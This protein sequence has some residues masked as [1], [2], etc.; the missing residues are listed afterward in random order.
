MNIFALGLIQ[1]YK[2]VHGT[3]GGIHVDRDSALHAL[4]ERYGVPVWA[5]IGQLEVTLSDYAEVTHADLSDPR[6]LGSILNSALPEAAVAAG[7]HEHGLEV[8]Y[9]PNGRSNKIAGTF[10]S[11]DTEYG[12]SFELHL[13][14]PQGGTSKSTHQFAGDDIETTP[15]FAGFAEAAPPDILLFLACHLSGTGVSVARA[16]FKFADKVDQRKIEV[17]RGAPAGAMDTIDTRPADGP[18]GYKLTIKKPKGDQT[19][20]GSTSDKRGDAA[21]SS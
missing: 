8:R 7:L 2:G 14:G 10:R 21:S 11:G 15:M 9:C 13:S 18:A 6:A 3:K 4:R 5:L 12:V 1:C 17:H 19:E 20:N 16:F